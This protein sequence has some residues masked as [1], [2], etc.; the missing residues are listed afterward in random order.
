MPLCKGSTGSRQCQIA[1]L[2]QITLQEYISILITKKKL[3]LLKRTFIVTNPSKT[4]VK[5]KEQVTA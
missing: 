4:D 5:Q 3:F 1:G 2:C